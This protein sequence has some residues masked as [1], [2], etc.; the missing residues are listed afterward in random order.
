MLHT[1]CNTEEVL[2]TVQSESFMHKF[3]DKF[4]NGKGFDKNIVFERAK[5]LHDDPELE[6]LHTQFAVQGNQ[7]NLNSEA[8]CHY[9]SFIKTKAGTIIEL[10]GRKESPSVK[11]QCTK[12]NFH[13]EVS[14]ILQGYIE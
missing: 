3:M 8:K 14:K 4:P 10:D 12:E 6:S 1:L 2:N 7:N 11:G 5:F 9:V 13:L